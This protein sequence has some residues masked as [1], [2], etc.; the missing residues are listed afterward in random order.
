ME[1]VDGR[2]IDV[3]LDGHCLK[4]QDEVFE[5]DGDVED[6]EW[7]KVVTYS[8]K[9]W[10]EKGPVHLMRNGSWMMHCGYDG[11]FC[12]IDMEKGIKDVL[13][14]VSSKE[15]LLC[16]IC[17]WFYLEM[18]V[19]IIGGDDSELAGFLGQFGFL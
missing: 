11:C 9:W 12:Q 19:I 10:F 18:K 16:G 1:D 5:R 8:E 7:T 3:S 2:A 15:I 17:N 4:L 14:S 13:C 6:G